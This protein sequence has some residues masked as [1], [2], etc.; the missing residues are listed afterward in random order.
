MIKE[1]RA[2]SKLVIGVKCGECIHHKLGPAVFEAKC[3]EL[4]V[5]AYAK[6]CPQFTPNLF[7]I[8]GLPLDFIK[9]LG[10]AAKE[11]EPQSIRILS[12]IFKNMDYIHRHG[13]KFGQPVFFRIEDKTTKVDYLSN[14]FKAYVIS[15]AVDGSVVYLAGSLNKASQNSLLSLMKSSILTLAQFSKIRQKLIEAGRITPESAKKGYRHPLFI[16]AKKTKD[17]KVFKDYTP[18]TIDTVP[19]SWFETKRPK[20]LSVKEILT[21]ERTGKSKVK[22]KNGMY[23]VTRNK[24]T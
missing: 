17:P 21:P 4:G 15:V 10:I 18:P 24:R 2:N 11:L 23:E 9:S 7:K 6:A 3:S 16:A 22:L 19:T 20:R 13:F 14:Y 1:D 8:A 12:Y 5:K